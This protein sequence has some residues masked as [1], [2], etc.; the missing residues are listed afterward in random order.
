M[1]EDEIQNPSAGSSSPSEAVLRIKQMQMVDLV[2]DFESSR[3]IQ[4]CTHLPNFEM[5][6]AWIE[7]ALK[8]TIPNSYFENKGETGGTESSERRSV[9]LRK[10]D[11][12][13]DQRPLPGYWRSLCCSWLRWYLFTVTLR[14]D[15]VQELDRKDPTWWRLGQCAQVE[16]SKPCENCMTRKFVRIHRRPIIRKW[17]RWRR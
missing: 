13:H 5:L 4:C 2:D 14:N 8:R 16:N 9:P 6:V 10:T 7:S 11:L 12:L 3:S 17:K 15:D 1:L